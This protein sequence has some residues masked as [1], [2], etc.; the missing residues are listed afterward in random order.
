MSIYEEFQSG[1]ARWREAQHQ[2][3]RRSISFI[4]EFAKAFRKYLGAPEQYIDP[5]AGGAL[6]YVEP[7]KVTQ[8]DNGIYSFQMASP[9][10]WL[11]K[12][13]DGFWVTGLQLAVNSGPSPADMN[14]FW[15]LITFVI[16][17]SGCEMLIGLRDQ[18]FEFPA[19]EP[20]T[21][22]GAFEYM[23]STAREIL[24]AA[25]WQTTETAPIGFVHSKS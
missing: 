5:F 4:G 15:Y 20:D 24:A 12:D 1:T 16:R 3:H 7:V 14:Y 18:R 25:P 21:F 9:H 22:K 17:D 11:A 13:E 23:S 10:Q 19:N 6:S 8:D 2:Y